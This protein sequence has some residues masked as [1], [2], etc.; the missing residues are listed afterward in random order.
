MTVVCDVEASGET[1][2]CK[3]KSVQ[4][5]QDFARAA[6]EYVR[7]A[8]YAPATSNGVPVKEL[9]HTYTISFSLNDN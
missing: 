8:R 7:K 2:N 6:L 1:S 3:V 5:G 4:G 9:Q